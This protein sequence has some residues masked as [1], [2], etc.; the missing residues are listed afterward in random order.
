M[1]V[2]EAVKVVGEWPKDKTVP[3]RLRQAYDQAK[4]EEKVQIGMLSEALMAAAETPE[5]FAL[6]A[7]HWS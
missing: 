7:K 3:K 2:D 4:G 1:T 6:V 5:D